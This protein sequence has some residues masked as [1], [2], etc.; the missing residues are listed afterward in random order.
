MV[1]EGIGKV[2]E[3]C[4]NTLQ[5]TR[6][7]CSR[8]RSSKSACAACVEACPVPGAVAVG[9]DGVTVADSCVACGACVS[10]C[11][12]GAIQPA[13]SDRALA[14]RMRALVRREEPF[15]IACSRAEA[16][17][18]LEVACL[19]R[20]TEALLLEP[21]RWGAGRVEIVSPDC[22]ACSFQ[23]AMPRWEK[24]PVL[25]RLLCD[26]A[27]VDPLRITRA[28][29]HTREAPALPVG[30]QLPVGRRAFLRSFAQQAVCAAA[31]AIPDMEPRQTEAELFREAIRQHGTNPK[32]SH[33]LEV[34]EGF[35]C[36]PEGPRPVPQEGLPLADIEVS[37]A[38]R[39]CNVCETLCP[40]GALIRRVEGQEFTL[41]F[42]PSLCTACRVCEV[43]CFPKAVRIKE[44]FDLAGLYGHRKVGLVRAG[45]RTCRACQSDFLGD[46]SEIC[47]LCIATQER[48]LEPPRLWGKERGGENVHA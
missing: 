36:T 31:D 41:E 34:L 17:A 11:P 35:A 32:R 20:L 27:G 23:K 19:S 40:V 22:S 9:E 42:D 37:S 24:V 13:E 33:L 30:P 7:L 43:A 12:N 8:Y 45:I 5:V 1:L 38:C 25:A 39:G 6:G 21:V 29:A 47:P 2:L 16:T 46:A 48:R 3:R 26:G 15:R 18:D 4:G 10:A 44:T 28:T 14:G